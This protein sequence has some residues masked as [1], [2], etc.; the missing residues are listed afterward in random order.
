[1][2]VYLNMFYRCVFKKAHKMFSMA[3]QTFLVLFIS[4]PLQP[5]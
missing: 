1:M 3:Y 4:P 2:C 5:K